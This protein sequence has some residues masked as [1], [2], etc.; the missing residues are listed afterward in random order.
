MILYT[1][2]TIVLH[3]KGPPVQ[4]P[5]QPRK[6]MVQRAKKSFFQGL[7]VRFCHITFEWRVRA[8]QGKHRK[9]MEKMGKYIRHTGNRWKIGKIYGTGVGIDVPFW[10]FLSHHQTKYLLDI[11]FPLLLGDVKHW[12]IYQ[13]LLEPFVDTLTKWGFSLMG[14]PQN[15]WLIWKILPTMDDD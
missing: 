11:I 4:V 3:N 12:D 7:N 10:G 8:R 9:C 2:L 14:V 13:P 1:I 5:T 15:T 6:E